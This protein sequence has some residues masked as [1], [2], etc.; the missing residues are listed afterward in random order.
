MPA[1]A[2]PSKPTPQFEPISPAASLR[3]A[4]SHIEHMSAWITA[5]NLGT[6]RGNYSFEA[7]GEDIDAIRAGL[8]CFESQPMPLSR[9]VNVLETVGVYLQDS[10]LEHTITNLKTNVTLGALVATAVAQL[11]GAG[12]APSPGDAVRERDALNDVGMFFRILRR[13]SG[14]VLDAYTLDVTRAD[15]DKARAGYDLLKAA[16]A[17]AEKAGDDLPNPHPVEKLWREIGLPEYFLGNGGTN[18]KLYQ[19]YDAIRAATPTP[20]SAPVSLDAVLAAIRDNVVA[21][22]DETVDGIDEA[23]ADVMALFAQHTPTSDSDVAAKYPNLRVE[24]PWPLTAPRLLQLAEDACAS[25]IKLIGAICE[26]HEFEPIALRLNEQIY[27]FRTAARVERDA[28]P[29]RWRHVKRGTTYTEVARGELQMSFVGT[30]AEGD[31]LIAYRSESDGRVW[32]RFVEE[33]EDG[34]FVPVAS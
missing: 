26:D 5:T 20:P 9:V 28:A 30:V 27:A 19:L 22:I 6:A 33:F 17:T 23:A 13:S 25:A 24:K 3:L 2:A 29:K 12:I 15:Y 31:Q 1:P 14:T 18:T 10:P 21:T 11:K 16:L 4:I 7:L 8:A 34:R 32:F